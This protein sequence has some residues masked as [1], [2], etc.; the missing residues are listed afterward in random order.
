MTGGVPRGRTIVYGVNCVWWDFI[1]NAATRENGL[2]CC[3]VCRS[4]L[5]QE[6]ETRWWENVQRHEAD[7][8]PGYEALVRWSQ[9]K[10]FRTATDAAA[11]RIAEIVLASESSGEIVI[12]DE[13]RAAITA[14]RGLIARQRLRSAAAAEVAKLREALAD[15]MNASEYK[16]RRS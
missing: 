4:V 2:P 8:H 7:G 16:R 1:E 6:D 15:G 10:C 9:G 11:Q 13:L 5:F 3:P 12:T 14:H